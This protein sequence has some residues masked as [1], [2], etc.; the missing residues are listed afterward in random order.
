MA[1]DRPA[2]RRNELAALLARSAIRSTVGGARLKSAM[3]RGT[4]NWQNIGIDIPSLVSAYPGKIYLTMGP[5]TP[6]KTDG[7]LRIVLGGIKAQPSEQLPRKSD[8]HGI[9]RS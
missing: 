1:A 3:D 6:F 4:E 2:T 5:D 8:G 7:T 9:T